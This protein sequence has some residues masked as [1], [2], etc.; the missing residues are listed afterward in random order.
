MLHLHQSSR[1]RL[2]PHNCLNFFFL[3]PSFYVDSIH[4]VRVRRPHS[5]A[6]LCSTL[7]RRYT[8]NLYL[9][10]AI[11]SFPFPTLPHFFGRTR[12]M[13]RSMAL[14]LRHQYPYFTIPLG[15]EQW[16]LTWQHASMAVPPSSRPSGSWDQPS[17][18]PVECPEPSA[19]N[20]DSILDPT[21]QPG[22]R[23]S[24]LANECRFS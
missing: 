16:L 22:W 5:I 8:S 23:A 11:L 20:L 14:S 7:C 13:F 10:I 2:E 1:Q 18:H 17:L 4:S 6:S 21:S 19:R 24:I 3:I 12:L 9:G 15:R